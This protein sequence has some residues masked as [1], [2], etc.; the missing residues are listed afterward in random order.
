MLGEMY[1]ADE[2]FRDYYDSR[3]GA[4]ATHENALTRGAFGTTPARAREQLSSWWR[5]FARSLPMASQGR[6]RPARKD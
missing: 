2:R 4:G 6:S 3:A 1:L 5:R